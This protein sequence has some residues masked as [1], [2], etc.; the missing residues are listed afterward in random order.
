MNTNDPYNWHVPIYSQ[1]GL[2]GVMAIFYL[3]VPESPCK[4]LLPKPYT[5]HSFGS[6]WCANVGRERQGKQALVRFYKGVKDF[7]VDR[8][9]EVLV[10]TV[11]HEKEV[12]MSL[13]GGKWTDIFKG[14]DGV[15]QVVS[16]N[17][18]SQLTP[19]FR[20]LACAWVIISA[21]WLGLPLLNT[22]AAYFFSNIGL[23]NPFALTAITKGPQIG[24]G[25]VCA[26]L[27]DKIGRRWL[28]CGFL[29]VMWVT[30]LG[31]A[32]LGC[33]PQSNGATIGLV[34]LASVF[35]KLSCL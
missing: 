10:L 6:V 24:V 3:V 4:C 12:A 22:Y 27:V 19:Q 8:Q 7:D 5:Q 31:I 34:F 20:T 18:D 13:G 23:S 25:I 15:S 1:W 32:I 29:S 11:E 26:F 14:V 28:A 30:D 17:S 2:I 35:S 9:W 21:Q 16:V 33:V